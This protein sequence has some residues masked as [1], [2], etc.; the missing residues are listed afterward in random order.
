MS[1]EKLINLLS[2]H[3]GEMRRLRMYDTDQAW[4]S[5]LAD[6]VIAE[7]WIYPSEDVLRSVAEGI[8]EALDKAGLLAKET[9]SPPPEFT[10]LCRYCG[11]VINGMIPCPVSPDRSHYR[12]HRPK[13]ALNDD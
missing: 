6:T 11:K 9:V 1:R 8:T 10:D 12:W 5:D 4:A 2:D 7:G 3:L 13:E